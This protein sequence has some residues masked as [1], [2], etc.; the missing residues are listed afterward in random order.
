MIQDAKGTEITV[1]ARVWVPPRPDP[2]FPRLWDPDT[3]KGGFS[4][5][6]GE[7]I[8]VS[9]NMVTIREYD[10]GGTRNIRPENCKVQTTKLKNQKLLDL[11][12]R[13]KNAKS[14]KKGRRAK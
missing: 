1:G 14:T 3:K 8:A 2:L 13:K 7:V 10:S 5:Y 12:E 9:E 11:Y 6:K 4:G